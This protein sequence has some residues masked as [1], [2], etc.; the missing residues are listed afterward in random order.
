MEAAI[1]RCSLKQ[2]ILKIPQYAQENTRVGVTFK[3]GCFKV[4]Y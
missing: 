4:P 3:K 2:V 1:R